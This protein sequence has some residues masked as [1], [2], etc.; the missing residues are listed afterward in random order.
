MN[1]I[2]F[3]QNNKKWISYNVVRGKLWEPWKLKDLRLMS[4]SWSNDESLLV[5]PTILPAMH[6]HSS[7]FRTT[8]GNLVN[9][10]AKIIS[11]RSTTKDRAPCRLRYRKCHG[12]SEYEPAYPRC[13]NKYKSE[14]YIEPPEGASCH[15]IKI[16]L[17]NPSDEESI[18][19]SSSSVLG[20]VQNPRTAHIHDHVHTGRWLISVVEPGPLRAAR[21]GPCVDAHSAPLALS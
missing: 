13:F 5:S 1:L 20:I 17:D 14:V 11:L 4:G 9:A 15:S 10:L 2:E 7:N 6:S 16:A 8:G 19:W 12:D 3:V 21:V 18:R